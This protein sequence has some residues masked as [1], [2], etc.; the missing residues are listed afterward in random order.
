MG[1]LAEHEAEI[2]RLKAELEQAQQRLSQMADMA[3]I[4]ELAAN[5]AHEIRNPLAGISSLTEVLRTRI[6]ATGN[7]GEILDTILDEVERLNRIVKDLLRFARPAKAYL[8]PL[9]LLDSVRQVLAFLE[10]RLTEGQYTVHEEFPESSPPVMAD[11][12]QL[13]QVFL[14]ILLNAMEATGPGGKLTIR[15]QPVQPSAGGQALEVSFQD[16]G[17]GIAAEDLGKIF[18]PFF[19]TKAQ[20]TG[21]GLAA[22]RKILEH[23][24]GTIEMQSAPGQGARFTVRLP[25][26]KDGV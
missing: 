16:N 12:D 24:G 1:N 9:D 17:P 11:M 7:T 5:M 19:T 3:K 18:D 15:V 13:R 21:L 20:G 2:A 22:C 4:G 25:V 14:N 8:V 10:Q 6:D 23:H 26:L